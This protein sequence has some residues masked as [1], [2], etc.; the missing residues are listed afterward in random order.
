MQFVVTLLSAVIITELNIALFKALRLLVAVANNAPV[1]EITK[2]DK[3]EGRQLC[4]TTLNIPKIDIPSGLLEDCKERG[5]VV[6]LF[7]STT[8]V[9][10]KQIPHHNTCTVGR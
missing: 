1:A 7:T 2:K 10:T 5:I 8:I 3:K 4:I 6:P 9:T